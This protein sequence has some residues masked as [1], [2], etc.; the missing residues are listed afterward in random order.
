M[1]V[2]FSLFLTKQDKVKL[3]LTQSSQKNIS[4]KREIIKGELKKLHNEGIFSLYSLS[5]IIR[6]S[7]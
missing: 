6:A 4:T 1:A 7:T 2:K 5:H 3:F